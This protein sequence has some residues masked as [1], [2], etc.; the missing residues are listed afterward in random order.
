[1]EES[2]NDVEEEHNSGGRFLD[3]AC[4][5]KLL[6]RDKGDSFLWVVTFS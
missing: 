2:I 1:M 6:F 5:N 3:D 4:D